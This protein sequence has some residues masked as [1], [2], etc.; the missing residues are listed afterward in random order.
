MAEAGFTLLDRRPEIARVLGNWN[1]SEIPKWREDQFKK[2]EKQLREHEIDRANNVSYLTSR[3]TAIREGDDEK[4]LEWAALVYL[5]FHGSDEHIPGARERLIQMTDETIADALIEGIIHYAERPTIPTMKSV[6]DSWRTHKIPSTHFLLSLSVFLRLSAGMSIPEKILPG[7]IAAI[8]TNFELADKPANWR[9]TLSA[10]FL[11]QARKNPA[12]VGTVLCQLW[13][14]SATIKYGILPGFH[15]L[16]HDSSSLQFLASVS[17]DVL[18]KGIQD[19]YT[20]SRL[21]SMLLVHDRQAAVQIGETELARPE[22]ATEVQAIWST[23]LYVID[24][25][26]YLNPWKT[27]ASGS[28]AG[29]WQV[30]E[31]I[32]Q[33]T[34]RAVSLT[35]AQR[36]EIIT[37]V[38]QRFAN[39]MHPVGSSDGR[40]NRW[41]AAEFV[42]NQI[43]LLAADSSPDGDFHLERLEND[44]DL[45][46]YR[47]LVRHLRAQRQREQRESSFV[48]ASPQQVAEAIANRAPATPN[49][50]L[51]FIM[52]HLNALSRDLRMTQNE[53]Y[54]AYWNEKGRSPVKPKWEE[55]CSGLLA[56][57]LQNRTKTHNLIVTVEHHMIE[58]KECDLVV[59]Q[60]ADRLL[61]IEAKHH[62]HAEVWT[63]WRTQL[64]RLYTRDAKAGGLGIYLI[65]WS[66]VEN[67]R[68]IPKPPEGIQRPTTATELK[69]A[70]E[71]L[72]PEV[73]RH[74][75]R[76]VIVDI[77]AP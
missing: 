38:G 9:E 51:A 60:G 30:I 7:S 23:A 34:N 21:I 54:R 48:F 24:P 75:L 55:V 52:D 29:L 67:D 40:Q 20:L 70:L 74:R 3:L 53:G 45:A 31:L 5:G 47:D 36:T 15:E 37:I 46:S 25:T 77:S 13:I 72:I 32:G 50:L 66:G 19:L 18:K 42:E 56:S 10:W 26:K 73:D 8:V 61:P 2:R 28:D 17:S 33:R 4:A 68:I 11:D 1:V 64:D 35:S 65:F 6:I 27:L 58:D 39:V 14:T 71:L 43:K 63:A 76:V 12:V 49:D 59:L 62:Y 16:S 44:N 22:L 57:D 41:D 69:S